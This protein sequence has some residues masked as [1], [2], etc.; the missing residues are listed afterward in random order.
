MEVRARISE[1]LKNPI[2]SYIDH[3]KLIFPNQ[4]V[5]DHYPVLIRPET[6]ANALEKSPFKDRNGSPIRGMDLRF[7]SVMG[8]FIPANKSYG[9][10][11]LIL[12]FKGFGAYAD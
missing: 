2:D 5:I 10:D 6:L 9:M 12:N 1:Q 11:G 7:S 8:L 4:V 3:G